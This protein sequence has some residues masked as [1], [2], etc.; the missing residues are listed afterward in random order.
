MEN[1]IIC[2]CGKSGVGKSSVEEVLQKL[3]YLSVVS[4]TSRLPR[5]GEIP[6]IDYNFITKD[7]FEKMIA[8]K[9]ILEYT[10]RYGNLYGTGINSID[11]SKGDYVCTVDPKGYFN[12][13]NYFGNDVVG[14]YL[15]INDHERMCRLL[16]REKD[17]KKANERFY[18]DNEVF[19]NAE[20]QIFYKVPNIDVKTSAITINELIM[21]S[22][23]MKEY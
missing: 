6:G 11:L 22:I 4:Y 5:H 13:K 3:G 19:D 10:E 2:L 8:N 1:K 16:N 21:K 18:Q 20:K 17:V 7:T 14:I 12:L 23:R 9:E 15:Y